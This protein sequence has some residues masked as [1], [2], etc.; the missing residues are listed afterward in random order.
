MDM[1]PPTTPDEVTAAFDGP[2]YTLAAQPSV[3]EA[4]VSTV[5]YGSNEGTIGLESV[6]LTF[7]LWRNPGDRADPANLADI[8]DE[9]RGS[10]DADPVAPLPEWMLQTRERMRYPWLWEAVRTT[11]VGVAGAPTTTPE[12]ILVDHTVH[13][14]QNSFRTERMRP[15]ADGTPPGEL[16]GRPTERA[17]EHGITVVVDGEEVEGMRID[18]DAHVLA[19]A[20]PLGT[21]RGDRVLTAVIPR[22][23]LP[24]VR[25]E[26]VT[27]RVGSGAG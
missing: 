17:I 7:T 14:L 8:S 6:S 13:V 16:L 5:Q 20:A 1:P 9:L 19:L 27:R 18:T 21:T 2:L 25:V 23:H 15:S 11:R 24:L 3:E 12:R 4:S 10:L 26:F 22:D